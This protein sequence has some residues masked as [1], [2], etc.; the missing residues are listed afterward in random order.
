MTVLR[1]DQPKEQRNAE[2]RA[3]RA[4]FPTRLTEV[5]CRAAHGASSTRFGAPVGRSVAPN[6][7][8]S[9]TVR[10]TRCRSVFSGPTNPAWKTTAPSPPSFCTIALASQTWALVTRT[11]E[12]DRVRRAE[13]DAGSHSMRSDFA[14][15][16]CSQPRHRVA[17]TG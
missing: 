16:F 6:T 14:V 3:N 9:E 1:S 12:G 11:A 13:A 10:P 4:T 7:N 2:G 17:L 8:T 15:E 5:S